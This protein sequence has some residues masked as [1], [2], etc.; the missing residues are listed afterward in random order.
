MENKE[1]NKA[2]ILFLI[3]R[4]NERGG[5]GINEL[6]DITKWKLNSPY[7]DLFVLLKELKDE[8][9]IEL[10]V[11]SGS[12]GLYFITKEGTKKLKNYLN[13]LNNADFHKFIDSLP[14]EIG[15]KYRVSSL[16][17]T[18]LYSTL[19]F[20]FF[21]GSLLFLATTSRKWPLIILLFSAFFF[22]LALIFF[23]RVISFPLEKILNSFAITIKNNG[24]ILTASVTF[25]GIILGGYFFYK[26]YPN[27]FL[28][29]LFGTIGA[30]LVRIFWKSITEFIIKI[31]KQN[32]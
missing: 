22:G 1:S 19:S 17:H 16:E 23:S 15:L 4:D 2:R 6:L 12:N 10:K 21:K 13:S 27:D 28:V 18:L 30:V 25:I 20:L 14:S 26:R 9:L 3:E 24:Q 31:K 5:I 29:Y 11:D 32:S 7:T 8:K